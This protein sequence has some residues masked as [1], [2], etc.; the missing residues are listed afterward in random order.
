[1]NY[2]PFILNG[3]TIL[4]TGASSGIGKS[5][6]IECSKLG[7]KLIITGRNEQRLK[8]TFELLV[9]NDHALLLADISEA[10]GIDLLSDNLPQLNGVV[11]CAGVS[12]RLPLKFIKE[13]S[14][15][16]LHKINFI[17]PLM[18][19]QKLYKKKLLLPESSL[20][21][22]SSVAS[23]Y[24]SIGSIMYMS[25]KGALNSFVKGLAFEVSTMKIRANAIQPGM[26]LTELSPI[27]SDDDKL[28]DS[29]LYPLGRYGK[30][31]EVAW[32]AIYLL[33]DASKWVTGSILTIDGGL[34]LR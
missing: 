12:K 4:V 31:E 28:K 2:N 16:E 20:V 7:A 15:S 9:G 33:S 10:T 26:I 5:T 14:V 6:A 24:A 13:E 11:H 27:L 1:M 29:E 21:Y 3:K 30:P 19:T 17:A 23:S 25:S 8:E 34:T 32:A 22:I 18:L